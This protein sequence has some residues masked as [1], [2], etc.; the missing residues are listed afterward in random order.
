MA[1]KRLF[2]EKKKGFDIEAGAMCRD[3]KE[4]LGLDGLKSVRMINR[5]DIEGMSDAEIDLTRDTVF[6]EPQVDTITFDEIV[7]SEGKYFAM[8]YLPVRCH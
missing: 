7:I 3:L 8:E 6:A 2:V 5:Y 4:N 1:I